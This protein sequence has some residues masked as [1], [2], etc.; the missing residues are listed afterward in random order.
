M[1]DSILNHAPAST[2][3]E[4]RFLTRCIATEWDRSHGSLPELDA[5]GLDWAKIIRFADMHCVAPLLAAAVIADRVKNVPPDAVAGLNGRYRDCKQR[6]MSFVIELRGI[7]A[8][9]KNDGIR[10]IP[11]KGPV[12]MLASYKKIGLRQFDDLDLLVAPTDVR[13]AVASLAKIGYSGWSID[14]QWLASH[15]NTE[16]EH[17]IG[18]AERGFHIDLHWGMGRKYFTVPFDFDELWSRTTRTKLIGSPVPNLCP[19]DLVLYLCYHGGRHLFGRLS[20]VCDVAATVA[21]HPELNWDTLM[22]RATEMG[23]RRLTLVGLSLARGMFHLRIPDSVRLAIDDDPAVR[24][25]VVTIARSIFREQK[26]ASSLRQQVDASLF[27]MRT[28]ERM[29][30]RLQYLYWAVAPN[31]RDWGNTRLPWSLRFLFIFSRPV[32]LL[33]KHLSSGQ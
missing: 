12:L 8:C 26:P 31:V 17:G 4:W 6:G 1:A 25:L 9:L 23:A 11:L 27:H 10:C 24:T 14:E 15:L 18:C 5:A 3:A 32:R 7:V 21:A 13:G 22:V 30:D 16:S 33:K 28:R 29:S 20:W 19:E 2:R